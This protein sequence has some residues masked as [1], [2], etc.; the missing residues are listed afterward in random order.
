MGAGP[1]VATKHRREKLVTA[2]IGILV[3]VAIVLVLLKVALF[4]G[5]LG[6]VA[7]VLLVLLLLGRI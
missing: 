1:P 7:L 2:F 6:L 4:G 5:L 3:A